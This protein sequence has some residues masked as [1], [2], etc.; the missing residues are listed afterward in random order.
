[1]PNHHFRKRLLDRLI[2]GAQSAGEAGLALLMTVGVVHC[3]GSTVTGAGDGG[4]TSDGGGYSD[5]HVTPE[6]AHEGGPMVE[7][8]IEAAL[9]WDGSPGPVVEAPAPAPD[10]GADGHAPV[11]EA[12]P[13][14][15]EAGSDGSH[16]PMIEAPTPAPQDAS[17]DAFHIWV[18]AAQAP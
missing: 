6:A 12:P 2:Q 16:F 9:G 7:A 18:E 8:A 15:Q 13:P 17:V 11:V 4:G 1:M 10:A 3:G 14:P 5:G